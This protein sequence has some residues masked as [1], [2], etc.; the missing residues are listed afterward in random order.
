MTIY[1]SGWYAAVVAPQSKLYD[2]GVNRFRY[3]EQ[4]A[5]AT[6]IYGYPGITGD[7]QVIRRELGMK[8][9][10][11]HRVDAAISGRLWPTRVIPCDDP[12]EP[13]SAQARE[14]DRAERLGICAEYQAADSHA[15]KAF[16]EPYLR[17]MQAKGAT[18]KYSDIVERLELWTGNPHVHVYR[19]PG[20]GAIFFSDGEWGHYH[21]SYREPGAHGTAMHAIFARAVPLLTTLGCKNIH[22]GG[23]TTPLPDDSL[24]KFKSR[25]GRLDWSVCFEEVP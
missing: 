14:A 22:L 16:R 12:W 1:D 25:I 18:E 17:A 5:Q 23:G 24:Y 19:A 2:D 4:N 7:K 20:A 8:L 13:G 3:V 15:L 11:R 9:F 10:I 6:S 21:L